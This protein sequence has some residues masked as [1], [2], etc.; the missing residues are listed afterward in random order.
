MMLPF[1]RI[2]S[3]RRFEQNVTPFYWCR[4]EK[5]IVK[6]SIIANAKYVPFSHH[7]GLILGLPRLTYCTLANK[8]YVQD[9][10]PDML[11]EIKKG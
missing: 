6:N 9:L 11:Q 7:D 2:V 3:L 5:V 1:V 10:N 8:Y 4:N